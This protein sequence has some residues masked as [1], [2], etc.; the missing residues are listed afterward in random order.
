M[1]PGQS[2]IE[3][4][5]RVILEE[6]NEDARRILNE[7]QARAEQVQRQAQTEAS[8]EQETILRRA[9]QEA[10]TVRSHAVAIAQRDAQGLRLRRREQLL[11]RAFVVARQHIPAI[12]DR[13]DYARVVRELVR[14]GLQN[15]GADEVVI[16]ADE[17]TQ[18]ALTDEMLAEM[19]R[20]LGVRLRIGEPL[21]RGTGVLMETADGH[22]RFDNTFE[23]R[24]ARMQE[25]LRTRVYQILMGAHG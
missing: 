9:R 20:G 8:A 17:R 14:E 5:E 3:A 12:V 1:S 19:S 24:L 6:A 15:L 2:N 11:E 25:A 7:A 22:R 4:L 16:R 10:E 23:A 21:S 18:Q 13:P